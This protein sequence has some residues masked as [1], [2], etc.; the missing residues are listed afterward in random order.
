MQI[1]AA[2]APK[3]KQNRSLAADFL[4]SNNNTSNK[5]DS[6][7]RAEGKPATSPKSRPTLLKA[8]LHEAP[9]TQERVAAPSIK[10]GFSRTPTSI[11][12]LLN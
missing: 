3:P 2:N 5:E 6:F 8:K 11:S 7:V 4:K 9:K 10:S 12:R 1:R